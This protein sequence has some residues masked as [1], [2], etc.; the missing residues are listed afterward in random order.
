MTSLVKYVNDPCLN[1]RQG[2]HGQPNEN[3]SFHLSLNRTKLNEKH[4]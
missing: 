2:K 1:S 3:K 4:I